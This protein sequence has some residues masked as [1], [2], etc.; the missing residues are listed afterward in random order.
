MYVFLDF[1]ASSLAKKGY[2]IE[3]GWM[4]E[5]GRSKDHLIR[6]APDWLDWD[7]EAEAIHGIGRGLLAREGRLPAEVAARMVAQ[8]SGHDLFASAPSWDG[9]WLSLLLRAGGLPR[10]TLRLRN[11]E[12]AQRE[13]AHAILDGRLRRDVD[14]TVE[15]L[16]AAAKERAASSA[17]AHRALRD[18]QREFATW[19]AVRDAAEALAASSSRPAA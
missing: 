19:R 9:K 18:A 11:T 5:D 14:L 6:P 4:F 12:E 16:M 2:P 1:E 17:P 7:A 10:H 8:L 3:I 13:T 15:T